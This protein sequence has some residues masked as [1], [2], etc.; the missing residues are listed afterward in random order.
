MRRP[1]SDTDAGC[2]HTGGVRCRGSGPVDR[3]ELIVYRGSLRYA[4]E[5]GART[6]RLVLIY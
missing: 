5:F 1:T 2:L 6:H 3:V 4:R